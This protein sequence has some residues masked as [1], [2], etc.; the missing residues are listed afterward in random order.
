MPV[1][2]ARI[3][4]ASHSASWRR[5]GVAAVCLL[6]AIVTA[7]AESPTERRYPWQRN[8]PPM[9]TWLGT[10]PLEEGFRTPPRSCGMVPFWSWNGKL[11]PDKLR[12]QID[13]M[14]EKGV[15]AGMMHARDGLNGTETP[16]FSEGWWE[17]VKTSVEHGRKAGFR[18]WIYDED[19]WPS[20]SAG[21]RTVARDP[22]R[23][24]GKKLTQTEQPIT[25]P[26]RMDVPDDAE[27][28]IAGRRTGDRQLDGESLVNLTGKKS[29]DCPAGDWLMMTYRVREVFGK[30]GEFGRIER[31]NYLNKD[32]VRD[33]IDITYEAYAERV[34]A[35][36]G[37]WVPGCFFD[38]IANDYKDVVWEDQFTEHFRRMKGYDL[39]P[40]LP[41]LHHDIGQ[42]TPRV[43]CDYYDVYTTLY[44]EAWF[45]Q[46]AEWCDAHNLLWT[47]HTI[48][49]I[50]AYMSQG[51]YFRTMRHL[52][53]PATDNED[54]RYTW[55]RIIDSFKPKQM[56]SVG[57]LY[58]RPLIGVEAAGGSGWSFTLESVRYAFNMLAAYGVN[59]FYGH[60]FHYTMDTPEGMDD[61]PNSW[62]FHNPY[63]KYFK[64]FADYSSRLS[65]ML[66]GTEHVVDVAVLYPT[67]NLWAYGP[68]TSMLETMDRLTAAQ[69]SADLI[70][71][72]SLSR[73]VIQDHALVVG[74]MR[75]RALIIPAIR[76]VARK[77]VQR[78]IEYIE[79]GGILIVHE[80]WPTD[81][82]EFG[83]DDP[84][85]TRLRT[86]AESRG[87]R[88]SHPADSV[89][90]IRLAVET[91]VR[92]SGEHTDQLAYHH[93]RR[94]GKDVY[95]LANDAGEPRTWEISFRATGA[96]SL[97]RPEDGSITPITAFVQRQGHT[98][99]R[100]TL[101]AR[102][103]CFVVFDPSNP[104]APGGF[105]LEFT[106]L[107]EPMF[108]I[109]ANGT[110][111]ATG[112]LAP[113]HKQ[114]HIAGYLIRGDEQQAVAGLEAVEAAPA[115]ITLVHDWEFL[116]VGDQLD[117]AWRIDVAESELVVPVMRAHWERDEDGRALGWHLP[118]LDDGRWRQIKVLDTLHADA[119][120]DRYRSRWQAR[121]ISDYRYRY[122]GGARSII[123]GNGLQCR[124][125]FDLP[126]APASGWLAVVADS[127]VR[128]LVNDRYWDGQ[129][130]ARQVQR[131]ELRGLRPGTNT[132][133][134]EPGWDSR[135][136][137]AEG[138][139]F[140]AD[141]QVIDLYTDATWEVSMDGINWATAWEYVA[142]PQ[143]PYGEPTYP[144]D[145]P[146]PSVLWYR[147]TLPPGVAAIAAPKIDGE[148][149]AWLDGEPL[150]FR[151]GWA[152]AVPSV[153]GSLLAI[154]VEAPIGKHGL[155]EPVRVRRKPVHQGLGSWTAQHLDWYSG[156]AIYSTTFT[157]ES[158]HK[159]EDIRL[160]LDLGKVCWCA[161]IWVN[162]KLAGTR[163]WPPYRLDIT[164]QA[165]V[166]E[167][168]L[169]IVVA[170]L[171]A[172][173]M[174][175]DIF[176]DVVGVEW[177][178]YWHDGNI[179]RDAWCLESGLIGPVQVVPMRRVRLT[180]SVG[181]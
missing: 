175:W 163:V 104:V 106:N 54:L 121:F 46:I 75:Y 100:L 16:Y 32:T 40:W 59:T 168:R 170:N 38:E 120:A 111:E 135:A 169:D 99:C 45:K 118:S 21:G 108:T 146:M 172:N 28:V 177:N 26:K 103:G 160:D 179:M 84:E 102:Q 128:L 9:E 154:R 144:D 36:F 164:T 94:Q 92:V 17:A 8:I 10:A 19:K 180:A 81:S 37:G 35:D 18:P 49:V 76:C 162:G 65:Y 71:P 78:I 7:H 132:L 83:R 15:Y 55:P 140:L 133:V 63:W 91:D 149:A 117:Y 87:I 151:D 125:R 22:A 113:R 115:T 29:W 130:F 176:D 93:I 48:E 166:G 60:L 82:A 127:F 39:I 58:G 122:H 53:I 114:A 34:G 25:G 96:P 43:R 167:N 61:W 3:R 161:E 119:G 77:E 41:A 88:P 24:I 136:V 155:L 156:R 4:R 145:V 12:W 62:F 147:Q 90:L 95:W 107:E 30:A 165:T 44:E 73:A 14:V 47:G 174:R 109:A 51:D 86:V 148:W 11:E 66:T 5:R 158:D 159:A 1:I 68:E 67:A 131:F 98:E 171:L 142:P 129:A 112:L 101:G 157:L 139:V 74:P 173:R 50:S 85:I 70:D 23:N 143:S 137:M 52:H 116:P 138:K 105:A 141:G 33:F 57:H 13:Q 89:K 42:R 69:I 134:I 97:W 124:L 123:G 126:A 181:G 72:D 31:P 6:T 80:R 20:G 64:Q 152:V 27:Y 153:T 2:T 56:A 110:V 178:R 150:T 79:A